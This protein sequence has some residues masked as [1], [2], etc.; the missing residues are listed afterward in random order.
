MGKALFSF[1][2]R[3]GVW[4]ADCFVQIRTNRA[5]RHNGSNTRWNRLQVSA[6]SNERDNRNFRLDFTV[7]QK[8]LFFNGLL[9]LRTNLTRNFGLG[10]ND[11]VMGYDAIGEITKW[12]ASEVSGV[13][14]LNE[15]LGYV[16]DAESRESQLYRTNGALVEDLHRQVSDQIQSIAAGLEHLP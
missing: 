9:G 8:E 2:E 3:L 16:Y 12:T 11:V 10:Y 1:G 15:Q 7:F 6:W 4:G 5:E 14:R 13:P